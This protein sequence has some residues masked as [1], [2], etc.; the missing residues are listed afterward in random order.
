V[1]SG[2]RIGTSAGIVKTIVGA[3]CHIGRSVSVSA[4]VLGDKSVLTDYTHLIH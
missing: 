4:V 3:G 1:R 2:S